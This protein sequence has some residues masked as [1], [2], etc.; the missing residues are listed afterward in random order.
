[1]T[2]EADFFE[3]LA[4]LDKI[5]KQASVQATPEATIELYADRVEELD[6]PNPVYLTQVVLAAEENDDLKTLR[7]KKQAK[8]P[9]DLVQKAHPKPIYVADGM[10]DGGLVENQNEQHEK[11]QRMIN[12]MPTGN[13]IHTWAAVLDDLVKI[14]TELEDTNPAAAELVDQTIAELCGQENLEKIAFPFIPVL[15]GAALAGIGGISWQAVKGKQ[16]GLQQDANQLVSTIDSWRNDPKFAA[17]RPL[18]DRLYDS[19]VKLSATAGQLMQAS[20]AVAATGGKNPADIQAANELGKRVKDLL[21]DLGATMGQIKAALPSEFFVATEGGI[22]DLM[23]DF[24]AIT[25]ILS[26]GQAAIPQNKAE[27]PDVADAHEAMRDGKTPAATPA[28]PGAA[29]EAARI[30]AVQEY[31]T[32]IG[33]PAPKTGQADEQT[34]QALEKFVEH[35]NTS[36]LE[37]GRI[38]LGLRNLSGARLA[39]EL[40]DDLTAA[41]LR[42]IVSIFED[43]AAHISL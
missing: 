33:F 10:G 25:S 3:K 39:Q 40:K 17:I 42:S 22:E 36:D 31:L 29:D 28:S 5:A 16:D 7:E 2:I 32:S 26:A 34:N 18:S 37:S 24:G 20:S 11:L 21:D 43:P 4:A 15:I 14:A 35:I 23:A 12:K 41:K 19:A 1:M 13:L 9:E 27:Q 6:V 30:R 38:G 8:E